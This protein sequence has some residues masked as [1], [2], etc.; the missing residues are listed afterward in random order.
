VIHGDRINLLQLDLLGDAVS[1][2]GRGDAWLNKRV[3]LAFHTIVGQNELTLPVLRSFVGQ[4]S[5]QFL[6]LTVDGTIDDP[7]THTRAFPAVTDMLEQL[8]D[9]LQGPKHPTAA[10]N[11]SSTPQR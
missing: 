8:Q 10:N 1:F 11:S 3:D 2:Y 5:E 9:D 7:Q 4:A 6:Q